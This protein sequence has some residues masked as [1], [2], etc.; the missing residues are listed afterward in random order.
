MFLDML[1]LYLV[2]AFLVGSIPFGL[3]IGKVF[4]NVD[5]RKQGS[6]SIGATNAGRVL[7]RK[8]AIITFI[9][10]GLKSFVMVYTTKMTAGMEFA[11]CVLFFVVMG[12]IYSIWLKGK[13]GKGFACMILGL[14]ALDYRLFLIA[15]ITWAL[16]FLATKI[17]AL[18]TL[19]STIV[20][21][22]SVY[23][24]MKSFYFYVILLTSVFI[25]FAHR[26]NIKRMLSGEELSF[27]KNRDKSNSG[28]NGENKTEDKIEENRK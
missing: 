10:D 22:T 21:T 20:L 18:A 15:G 17:S 24:L 13:G 5:I 2:V 25:I 1:L 9:L 6:G 8:Y 7:G 28:N 12:H 14:L 26:S 19:I 23:F 4:C 27:K 16:V 3:I 11:V